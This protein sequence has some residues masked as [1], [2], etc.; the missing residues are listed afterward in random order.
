MVQTEDFSLSPFFL[1]VYSIRCVCVWGKNLDESG[2]LSLSFSLWFASLSIIRS[3][4]PFLSLPFVD[5]W[6]DGGMK[7]NRQRYFVHT[8]THTY[9]LTSCTRSTL[10]LTYLSRIFFSNQVRLVQV[11]F[12]YRER[13]IIYQRVSYA[14]TCI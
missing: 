6:L 10:K 9:L 2:F 1:I 14:A 4:I 3:F 13:F 11:L 8:H 7:K 5:G 12:I